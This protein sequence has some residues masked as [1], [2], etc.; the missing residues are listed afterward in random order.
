MPQTVKS[1]TTSPSKMVVKHAVSKL[2]VKQKY[3]V[4]SCIY[5]ISQVK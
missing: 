5:L 3:K 2:N 4:L 1:P